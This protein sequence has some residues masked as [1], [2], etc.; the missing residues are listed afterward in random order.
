VLDYR[1]AEL[2]PALI[3]EY[4]PDALRLDRYIAQKHPILSLTERLALVRQLGEA[5]AFAHGK[6]LF[7]RGLAPRDI[8]VRNPES[9][10]PRLQITNW[11]VASRAQGSSAG[12]AM[13]KGTE[14]IGEHLSDPAKLYFAP[15]AGEGSEGGAA[16]ADVFSLGAI[17][18]HIFTGRP[19]AD[20]PLDLPGRLR[21]GNG[22]RLSGAMNGVGTWLE[23][24]VRA[25]QRPS[26][27]IGR[28]MRASSSTIWRRLKKRHCHP[29]R[30]H[31]RAPIRWLP[32]L[33]TFLTEAL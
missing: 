17:A 29:N 2:G 30:R 32:Q 23:E 8:L 3:F 20:S 4:D 10:M 19:P 33:G 25:A 22:L 28:A 13:T 27:V 16:Q 11:Q 15:E 7:H 1:E 24:M 21:E 18:C 5:M 9:D 26:F 14:H 31:L 6:S 12:M